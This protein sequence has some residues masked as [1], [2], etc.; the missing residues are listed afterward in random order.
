M[1]I[2][3]QDVDALIDTAPNIKMLSTKVQSQVL[4]SKESIM[5]LGYSGQWMFLKGLQSRLLNPI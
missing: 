3:D 1:H 2:I 5:K 4:L